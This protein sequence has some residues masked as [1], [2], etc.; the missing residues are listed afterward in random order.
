MSTE[1]F[2][3]GHSDGKKLGYNPVNVP[4]SMVDESGIIKPAAEF[5]NQLV[6]AEKI[7]NSGLE[8][9]QTP[10]KLVGMNDTI[11][12]IKG[13]HTQLHTIHKDLV[14]S[15]ATGPD[16][17]EANKALNGDK[18]A[19][20]KHRDFLGAGDHL[21]VSG[22]LKATQTPL[23]WQHISD[24]AQKLHTAWMALKNVSPKAAD[25]SITHSIN[26][27]PTLFTPGAEMLH[28]AKAPT[29]FK[30]RGAEPKRIAV[31][32]RVLP[33]A[34]VKAGINRA[35]AFPEFG[36]RKEALRAAKN[37]A[38]GTKR[39]R[40]IQNP[41]T[42]ADPQKDG[43]LV[44]RLGDISVSKTGDWSGSE[45]ARNMP[46]SVIPKVDKAKKGKL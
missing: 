33:T 15:G 36:V 22:L 45:G 46:E 42:V 34:K 28:I 7:I 23:A 25:V 8:K 1:A 30:E 29:T 38:K 27:A 9:G 35:E 21:H 40:K 2:N 12:I 16:M 20:P 5:K 41:I 39:V 19:D 11:N 13:L 43:Q 17:Y 26:S 24:G 44:D 10:K 14:K 18:S 3:L 6:S 37:K 32:D 4:T 31:D